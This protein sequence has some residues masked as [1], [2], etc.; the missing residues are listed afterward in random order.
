MDFGRDTSATSSSAKSSM[1]IAGHLANI[2]AGNI[3]L[4]SQA[5]NTAGTGIGNI[6]FDTGTFTVNNLTMGIDSGRTNASGRRGAFYL[7]GLTVNPSATGVLTVNTS[8][9]LGNNTNTAASGPTHGAF[10]VNGGT[11]NIGS[12]ITTAGTQGSRTSSI[13]LAGGT[14]NMQGHQIGVGA[15]VNVGLTVPGQTATLMNLGGGGIN[16]AGL[17]LQSSTFTLPDTAP[18][19]TVSATYGAGT[20]VLGG[21]NTYTGDTNVNSGT[22]SVAGTLASQVIIGGGNLVGTGTINSLVTLNSGN[23]GAQARR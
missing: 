3:T 23:L 20:L 2:T 5:G 15:A 21:N 1:N 8:L 22:L 6:T 16:G 19:T 17:T 13:V 9:V 18:T 12:D 7:G 10:V 4:G 14:L 11:G